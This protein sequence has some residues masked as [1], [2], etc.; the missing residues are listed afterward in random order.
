MKRHTYAVELAWTGNQGSGTSGY[1][2]FSRDHELRA[3][4]KTPIAG[5]SDPHFR[6]D[7]SRWNP[8]EMLVASLS[9]CHQLWYLHLAAVGG[10][11]VTAYEDH[12]EGVMVEEDDGAGQF[13]RVTLR[14]RVTIAPGGDAAL[15]ARLHHEAHHNCFIARSVNF[16]V[17]CE[18]E[19]LNAVTAA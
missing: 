8:E 2:A 15:A 1:R 5:S 6:G 19:I 3:P 12:P 13:E 17:V 10:V 9:A 4:G 14:P 11:V 7:A 16:E 18:P